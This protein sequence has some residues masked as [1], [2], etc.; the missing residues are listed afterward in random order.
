MRQRWWLLSAWT[1]LSLLLFIKPVIALV[2]LSLSQED[3]SHI[4]IIPFLSAAV[5]YLDRHKIF[6][7]ASMDK[8][9]G[10]L[11]LLLAACLSLAIRFGTASSPPGL[12]LS[13]WVL[14]LVLTWEA[15]FA[16]LFGKRAW[17]AATFPLL[18]LLLMVPI[19]NFALDRIIALLQEGSALIT[20]AFFDLAGVPALREGLVF[21]LTR[22][23]IEVAK[24]CSGIRSSMALLILA[25]LVAHFRLSNLWYKILFVTVGFFMMIVKN[26][27]RIATLTLLAVYVDPGFL[28]GRLHRQG[29]I[30][31]FLLALLLLLPLLILLERAESKLRVLPK[32]S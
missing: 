2:R 21:H 6:P 11:S 16:L 27:I 10:G 26:G 22:V 32:V 15:G 31:F 13:G 4:V 3:A 25:L 29:G 12:Q 14:A 18:F 24:E 17:K 8:T 23:N 1:V 7:L 19:P 9:L 28:F 20:G 30:V 5:L